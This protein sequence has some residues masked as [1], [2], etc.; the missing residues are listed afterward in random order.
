[1]K[2]GKARD[3]APG[4]SVPEGALLGIQKPLNKRLARETKERHGRGGTRN[5]KVLRHIVGVGICRARQ[6]R[7]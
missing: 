4:K 2:E 6:K 7:K 3:P 1:L 5:A